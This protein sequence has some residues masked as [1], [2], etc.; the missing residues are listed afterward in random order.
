MKDKK[1][2]L[3]RVIEETR[4]EI[5]G[6]AANGRIAGALSGEGYA[7]G[8]YDAINDVILFLNGNIP[9]RRGYW[10]FLKD[11]G[12]VTTSDGKI[13]NFVQMVGGKSFRCECGANVFHKPDKAD[14]MLYKCNSCGNEYRGG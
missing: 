10:D 12:P 11:E 1:K 14:L 8:Y 6:N 7:G 13:E 3:Q 5:A 2:V 4:K 9:N